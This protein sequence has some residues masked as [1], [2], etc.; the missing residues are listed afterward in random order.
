MKIENPIREALRSGRIVGLVNHTVLVSK[1]GT[2]VPL[3]DSASPIRDANGRVIGGVLVSETFRNAEAE[4]DLAAAYK[5][6]ET[7]AA[8][9]RRSNEDLSQF[10]HVASH[11]LRSPLNTIVQFTQLLEREYGAQLGEGKNLLNYQ[12]SAPA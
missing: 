10:A 12:R 7:Q 6:I 3:D 1:D 2:L 4:R 11:D 8:E 9:L 5:E